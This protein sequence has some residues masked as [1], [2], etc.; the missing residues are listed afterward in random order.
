MKVRS[1]INAGVASVLVA[2]LSIATAGAASSYTSITPDPVEFGSIVPGTSTLLSTTVTNVS[3]QTIKVNA[4]ESS[5]VFSTDQT[6][7]PDTPRAN[8]CFYFSQ[9]QGINIATS[10]PPQGTCKLYFRFSPTANG[11]FSTSATV[12]VFENGGSTIATDAVFLHGVGAPAEGPATAGTMGTDP[13]TIA[14]GPWFTGDSVVR[15]VT[16]TNNSN[17]KVIFKGDYPGGPFSNPGFSSPNECFNTAGTQSRVI[18]IGG[19]CII[20]FKFAPTA[21]G[22]FSGTAALTMYG[23]SGTPGSYVP[24][25]IATASLDS[26][27][28]PLSGTGATAGTTVNPT[29]L[30]FGNVTVGS[31]ARLTA[32]VT[33]TSKA[34]SRYTITAPNGSP[35]S[36]V[37]DVDD[38]SSDSCNQGA[39]GLYVVGTATCKVTVEFAPTTTGSQ[40]GTLTIHQGRG[41]DSVEVGTVALNTSGAGVAAAAPTFT[42]TPATLAFGNV[43]VSGS[44][45]LSTVVKN[46]STVPL[47]FRPAYPSGSSYADPDVV[48]AYP[49][50]CQGGDRIFQPGESCNLYVEFRPIS[51]G[52]KPGSIPVE[53]FRLDGPFATVLATKTLTTSGTG[54]VAA[55]SMSPTT[56]AFGNM[57][58]S[59][60][61]V[62]STV[63]TNDSSTPL[64]IRP[65]Y[66]AGS[67]YATPEFV[68]AYPDVCESS[69]RI[70]QV[71][72]SCHLYVEFRPTSTGSKPGSIPVEAYRLDGPT[73]TVLATKTLT[74]SGTGVAVAFTLTPA[75][76]AFGNVTVSDS[77]VLS[78]V[79]KNTST[80]PLRFRPAYPSGSSYADPDVVVVYPDACQ[81]GDRILQPGE[82]CKLYVEFRPFS[83]GSKPGSIPVEAFRLDGPFATVLATKTL[84]TSGTGVEATYTFNPTSLTFGNVT[85]GAVKYLTTTVTNTSNRSLTFSPGFPAGS[86]YSSTGDG[87]TGCRTAEDLPRVVAPGGTCVLSVRFAPTA[88]GVVNDVMTVK[89]LQ[90]GTPLELAS[91]TVAVGGTGVEPTYTFS[92][93]SLAFGSVTVFSS[94]T[95][96]TTVTNTSGLSLTFSPHFP[97]ESRYTSVGDGTTGCRTAEDVPRV[98][99]PGATC[100]LTVRF[101]P[102]AA[103]VHNDVMTVKAFQA[104]T[105][106]EVASKTV[107]VGG[108]GIQPT[109][110]FSPTSLAFGNVT[111]GAVRSLTTTI[112]NTSGLAMSFS[113]GFGAGSKYAE[114]GD[115]T[116]GCRTTEGAQRIVA[117]GGTCVVTV[118]FA[119]TANG[120]VNDVMTVRAYQAGTP[121][122][123]ASKTVRVGGTGVAP[124]YTFGPASLAFGNVTVG[125][126]KSLTTTVTNT[127]GLALTFSPSFPAGSKYSSTG[128]GTTGCRTTEGAPRVVAPGGTCVLAVRFAPT[129]TGQV[130]AVMTVKAFQAGTPLEVGSKTVNVGGTGVAAAYTFN[131]TSL[132]FGSIATGT[133]LVKTV[134]VTNNSTIGLSFAPSYGSANRYSVGGPLETRD[135][136]TASGPRLIPPRGS[137]VLKIAF[138]PNARATFNGTVVVNVSRPDLAGGPSVAVGSKNITVSG[139][140]T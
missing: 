36:V 103:V 8:A 79:V 38:P 88:T 86:A 128:D 126:A 26:K 11:D 41:S 84:T 51:T 123:V 14:F 27:G 131:P 53:A 134:T 90:A 70:L 6:T 97:A 9:A 28:V 92:P 61:K 60:S 120:L 32:T 18:S 49:N 106:L 12:G 15:G 40:P 17:G 132:S 58:L 78:T 81:G 115:G 48:V 116:T 93:T 111:V 114:L 37:P 20:S 98:V 74:T 104:G 44:K 76:V 62:L 135:C 82:S 46:T 85:V 91:E 121:L 50:A 73:T 47:R 94:R 34:P 5:P 66:P 107:N 112:T 101:A 87:T 136:V 137:C 63:V 108:T 33:N 54:V 119:P 65:R 35:Y 127:S 122:E 110:T 117:P 133:T 45:V 43:T 2:S 3:N 10:V 23:S 113:P 52:S 95:L 89:G 16:V 7:A 125:G 105:P 139:A 99:A 109:Y 13:T 55:F 22:N 69:E 4:S 71:G 25:P 59:G 130:N 57:T 80:I 140:G 64:R 24:T 100:V 75:T 67:M 39:T 31:K 118:R 83:T 102:M 72:E 42:L 30:A 129:A 1:W 29:T 19:T 77:R 21:A 138:S 68:G 96:T 56:L 124:T